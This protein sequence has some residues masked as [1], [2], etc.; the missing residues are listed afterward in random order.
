MCDHGVSPQGKE[1]STCSIGVGFRCVPDALST[2]EDVS[3][4]GG[5][6]YELIASAPRIRKTVVE[7]WSAKGL[8]NVL[9]GEWPVG[10]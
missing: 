10:K 8:L 2:V 3:V 5:K 6:I 1:G 4:V 7:L 9:M